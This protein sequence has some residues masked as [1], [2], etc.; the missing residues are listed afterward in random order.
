MDEAT[1]QWLQWLENA[2]QQSK[3]REAKQVAIDKTR[4]TRDFSESGCP[5]EMGY[6]GFNPWGRRCR[7]CEHAYKS[8]DGCCKEN[9]VR[10]RKV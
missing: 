6:H 2:R 7:A 10:M 4:Q 9:P 5:L 1:K 8:M 3:E